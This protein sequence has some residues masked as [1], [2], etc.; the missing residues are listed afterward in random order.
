M[1]NAVG[2]DVSKGKSTIAVL[3]PAGVIVRKPFDVFHTSQS[4]KALSDYLVSLEGDTR[5]VMECTGRYHEPMANTLSDAGLFVT[6]VNPHL[7][8]NFGNNTLRKV[9][10]DPADAKKIARYTL[11]NWAELRQY[12]SMDNT[13]NQLKTLNSQF[14]F[15]MRQKVAAKANLI[16]L[17]DNT[18]PG[19]NKLFNSPAREDGS[20]KWVDY[21]YSFWHVDC[22]RKIGLK[23]FSERYE[24]FCRKHHYI[25]QP[26]KP[27]ELFNASK[28]LVAVFPKEKSYRLLIRQSIQQLN[29]ASAH[30]ERLRREMNELASTL[31]EYE[32]VMGMYGVGKTYGPQLIAE[33]GD[34]SRFTHREALTAFAGVD[35]GVDQ[36]GQHSSKSNK[37]SK[38]GTGRLRKTLFQIMT[39]LLQNAPEDEPV[40]QFLNR[41]RSEGKPYYVYMTAGAN[42]FLR[43]YYGKVKAHLRSLE[44]NE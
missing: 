35:P 5:V 12:S 10:S 14:S 4:L 31:P 30:I 2:I 26:S 23:A 16:A 25:Y 11:D 37:A 28:E 27:E 32:V 21:A 38:C 19:V 3:Q 40:Y 33:I 8:K 7:I 43:I 13:R 9:K 41:K 42:K 1:Y 15:F 36:S 22:V 17:L 6:V 39:T 18:Y 29:L 34:V 24:A 44:Q 20:E